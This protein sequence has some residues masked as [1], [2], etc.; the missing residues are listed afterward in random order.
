MSKYGIV[1][2]FFEPATHAP[3]VA[4]NPLSYPVGEYNA[5]GGPKPCG[6]RHKAYYSGNFAGIALPAR[7]QASQEAAPGVLHPVS[8]PA[9]G[10]GSGQ[11]PCLGQG[12]G[13]GP[14]PGTPARSPDRATRSP[15]HLEPGPGFPARPGRPWN[16][17]S[18]F[19]RYPGRARV[20]GMVSPE[21][22][23]PGPGD[24]ESW[25]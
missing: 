22:G 15:G 21:P 19:T 8:W 3:R 14:G 10:Q 25:S 6:A 4:K 7:L 23:R 2:C 20:P 13:P 16:P 17:A 18:V 9:P 24:R 5:P 11:G 12:P 1:F